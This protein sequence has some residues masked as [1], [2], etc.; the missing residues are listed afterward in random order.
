MREDLYTISTTPLTANHWVVS[1]TLSP[2]SPP[3]YAAIS[4]SWQKLR[5]IIFPECLF[6]LTPASGLQL[7]WNARC[8]F[9]AWV[10]TGG[11]ES[12]FYPFI[13]NS[14]SSKSCFTSSAWPTVCVFQHHFIFITHQD[15]ATGRSEHLAE[16]RSGDSA[17]T[18][19]NWRKWRREILRIYCRWVHTLFGDSN[20]D[21]LIITSVVF[22]Y[23]MGSF[24]SRTTVQSNAYCFFVLTGTDWPSCACIQT[25]H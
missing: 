19:P 2:G 21:G 16:I 7:F 11:M 13:T 17:L 15:I 20:P 12:T 22:Q 4:Y 9:I 5:L 10:W 25:S 1:S 24:L 23:L 18:F 8:Q 3:W 14:R 6:K